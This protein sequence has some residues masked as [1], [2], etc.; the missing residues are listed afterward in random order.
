VAAD[1]VVQPHTVD[2]VEAVVGVGEG[3]WIEGL[4]LVDVGHALAPPP[5]GLTF[6]RCLERILRLPLGFNNV[7]CWGS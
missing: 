6:E 2:L 4:V 7:S 1:L 3:L 5:S